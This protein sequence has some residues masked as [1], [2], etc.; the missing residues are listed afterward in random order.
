LFFNDA[1]AKPRSIFVVT[2]IFWQPK[3]N[4]LSLKLVF[5]STPK[6]FAAGREISCLLCRVKKRGVRAH[7]CTIVASSFYQIEMAPA[8]R[9]AAGNGQQL[10][11]ELKQKHGVSNFSCMRSAWRG[12]DMG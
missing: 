2:T 1:D 12:N 11:V 3:P 8:V 10:L 4:M 6:N 7:T 9:Y 5:L